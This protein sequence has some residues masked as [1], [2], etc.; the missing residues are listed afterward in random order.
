MEAKQ[1]PAEPTDQVEFDRTKSSN[2]MFYEEFCRLQT[3][4]VVLAKK[5]ENM[6]SYKQRLAKALKEVE[7][8][9]KKHEK[10]LHL[11][12]EVNDER[13]KRNRRNAQQIARRFRC[14]V[15]GCQKSYGME[16]TLTQ[17]IKIKHK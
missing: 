7:T 11:T 13:R 12:F 3:T 9:L 6:L 1:V 8:S 15:K 17:H 4:Q 5:L 16:G 14:P 10:D 2:Q